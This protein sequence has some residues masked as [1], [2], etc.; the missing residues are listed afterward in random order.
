MKQQA[1]ISLSNEEKAKYIPLSILN[2]RKYI[3]R[4]KL[5]DWELSTNHI[6]TLT[7]TYRDKLTFTDQYGNRHNYSQNHLKYLIPYLK[8]GVISGKFYYACDDSAAC[9]RYYLIPYEVT[10][11]IFL[12]SE[13]ED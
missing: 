10:D 13:N 9:I 6:E 3:H 11:N 2:G 12:C 7:L 4:Y 1:Y 5:D 8:N